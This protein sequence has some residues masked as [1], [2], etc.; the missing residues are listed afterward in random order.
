MAFPPL[1]VAAPTVTDAVVAD[2][3]TAVIEAGAPGI[4]AGV[5]VG[6][7]DGID[8]PTALKATIEKSTGTPFVNPVMVQVVVG[9]LTEQLWPVVA[10]T[11]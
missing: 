3:V 2:E 9:A 10:V 11:V 6:S 4:F 7:G 1:S 8:G 5:I